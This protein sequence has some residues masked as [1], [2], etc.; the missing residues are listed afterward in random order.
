[1]KLSA[2]VKKI[3]SRGFRATLQNHKIKVALNPLDKIY[4]LSFAESFILPF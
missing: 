2:K 4:F 3:L 1:M